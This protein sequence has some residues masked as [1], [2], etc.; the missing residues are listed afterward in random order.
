MGRGRKQ[1]SNR[2]TNKLMQNNIERR[3][4]WVS[5][6]KVSSSIMASSESTCAEVQRFVDGNAASCPCAEKL[7]TT[8]QGQEAAWPSTNGLAVV[9][10]SSGSLPMHI[11]IR[12]HAAPV[13]LH[14]QALTGKEK[15]HLHTCGGP[16][17]MEIAAD[18]FKSCVTNNNS[19]H[20]VFFP[21]SSVPSSSI[22]PFFPIS[23][24]PLGL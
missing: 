20:Y 3:Y 4:T 11:S 14:F 7:I 10:G 19:G 13:L 1:T 22:C 12:T 21:P 24:C 8:A 17:E 16:P 5:G 2:K 15:I 18:P 6:P 9:I 23:I